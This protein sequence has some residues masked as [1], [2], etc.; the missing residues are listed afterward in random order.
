M[1]ERTRK[2]HGIVFILWPLIQ[3]KLL[4]KKI[5]ELNWQPFRYRC[6]LSPF[7]SVGRSIKRNHVL[8]EAPPRHEQLM[9]AIAASNRKEILDRPNE[10]AENPI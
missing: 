5:A 1:M 9:P 8:S 10:L 2:E 7:D 4:K 6:L 3:D